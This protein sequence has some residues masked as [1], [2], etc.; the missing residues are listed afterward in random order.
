MD[1]KF[2]SQLIAELLDANEQA[3]AVM[4][5]AVGDVVGPEAFARALDARLAKAQDAQSH[6]IRDNL[7]TTAVAAVRAGRKGS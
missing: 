2:L 7:L 5:G 3:F 4:A 6:P 1:E